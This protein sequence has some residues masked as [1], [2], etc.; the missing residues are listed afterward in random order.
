MIRES[1]IIT[2]NADGSAHIAPLGVIWQD[3]VPV[4]APFHPSTTLANLR[5]R[6]YA[7][8]NYTDDVRIFAGCLTRRR[9]WPVVMGERLP[10]HRLAASLSHLEMEVTAVA[11]DPQRPRFTGRIVHE[12]S[13]AA[14]RG[15]NRAQSAVV[16]A[17][18]LVSRLNM[19][20]PEKINSEIN[21][22]SI[23]IQK[24]AGPAELEA[25]GWLMERVAAY[26]GMTAKTPA[27]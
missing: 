21:Y 22:L 8:I 5:A 1:I 2:A 23:A 3:E 18:I 12:A 7:T 15:F 4:L 19:L 24:T 10:V 13:H 17:A 16:E 25:W 11:D 9:D 27:S 6:P 26:R 20:P 14:F